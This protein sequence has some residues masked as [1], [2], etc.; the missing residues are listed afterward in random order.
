MGKEIKISKDFIFNFK[1][2]I[3]IDMSRKVLKK[4]HENFSNAF[5]LNDNYSIF[6]DTNILLNYY[7]MSNDNKEKLETF[8]K[9]KSKKTFLTQQIEKE[10]QRN[11]ENTISDYFNTLNE[12]KSNFESDLQIGV[13]NKFQRLLE[14]KIVEQDFPEIMSA[15][16]GIYD[17]LDTKLFSNDSLF[18]EVSKNVEKSIKDNENLLFIDPILDV[19][20]NFQRTKDLSD[21]ELNIVS[22]HYN[23]YLSD[24]KNAKESIKRR[25]TFPG[26]G[27]KKS[28]D[29]EGDFIIFHEIIKHMKEN[30]SDAILLTRDVT[31]SD[32]LKQDRSPYIHYILKVYQ[33][34]GNLLYIFDATDLLKI[35]SFENIYNTDEYVKSQSNDEDFSTKE[36]YKKRFLNLV[37]HVGTYFLYEQNLAN[38]TLNEN[39][40]SLSD[41][42]D[43]DLLGHKQDGKKLGILVYQC[44]SS[45]KG[46]Q[47]NVQKRIDACN[48]F[49]G[50]NLGSECILS[51]VLAKKTYLTRLNYEE[52]ES[53]YDIRVSIF[54]C[55]NLDK[56]ELELLSDI[57]LHNYS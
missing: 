1:N 26:C 15:I 27:E 3:G 45:K 55:K 37:S 41:G 32:W 18:E 24:Y 20:S 12:I 35:I 30:N 53:K 31:K 29:K 54:Y 42:I 44:G 28:S 40:S 21:E 14:S 4:Y 34:T 11:R 47:K 33:L 25:L 49:M 16:K 57:K 6:L 39:R 50:Y 5:E 22:E 10:F 17:E 19:F 38:I 23:Y 46:F 56:P 9:K 8:L 43:L 7:G 52:L 51:I 36:F 13:K 48:K 2:D